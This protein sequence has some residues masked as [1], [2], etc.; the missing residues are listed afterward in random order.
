LSP[1]VV[2]TLGQTYDIEPRLFG[3]MLKAEPG[4]LRGRE[5]GIP[6]REPDLPLNSNFLSLG[7]RYKPEDFVTYRF[8][9]SPQVWAQIIECSQTEG[10]SFSTGVLL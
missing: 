6:D 1:K 8:P 5:M 7:Y 10:K 3:R 9:S 2:E 4:Q